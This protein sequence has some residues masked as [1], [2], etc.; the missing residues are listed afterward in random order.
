[1]KFVV[2]KIDQSL[3]L[4]RSQITFVYIALYHTDGTIQ[5]ALQR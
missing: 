4:Y 3:F 1:V 5:A 2:S